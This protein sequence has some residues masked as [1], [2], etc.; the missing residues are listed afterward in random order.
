MTTLDWIK[1]ARDENDELAYETIIKQMDP[2]IKKLINR[3]GYYIPS[4]DINDLLQEGRMGVY[5][6]ILCYDETEEIPFIPFCKVLIRNKI[7][8]ALKKHL[9][10]KHRALN[11]ASSLDSTVVDMMKDEPD[12]IYNIVPSKE[13]FCPEGYTLINELITEQREKFSIREQDIYELR[14]QGYTYDEISKLTGYNKKQIDNA[15]Q[16]IRKKQHL[17][18]NE[19][20]T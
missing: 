13:A 16:K 12:E 17:L 8:M 4:G 1:K 6:A 9:S 10:I 2:Y 18:W 3:K 11:E 7:V 14:K 15:V 20:V 5:Y 19:R